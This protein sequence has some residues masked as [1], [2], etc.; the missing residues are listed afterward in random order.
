MT[1]LDVNVYSNNT[2][3]EDLQYMPIQEIA[4]QLVEYD[5]ILVY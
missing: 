4:L 2:N 1:E 3:N 5:H